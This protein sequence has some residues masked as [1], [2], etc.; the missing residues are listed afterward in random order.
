MLNIPVND[1]WQTMARVGNAVFVLAIVIFIWG[2]FDLFKGETDKLFQGAALFV[3]TSLLQGLAQLLRVLQAH[4]LSMKE[5]QLM[6]DK[7]PE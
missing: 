2:C 3:L 6:E 1:D 7:S 4:V 5:W